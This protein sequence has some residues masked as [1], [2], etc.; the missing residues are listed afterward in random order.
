MV[1]SPVEDVVVSVA[2]TADA[3]NEAAISTA[4]RTSAVAADSPTTIT[5]SLS[6]PFWTNGAG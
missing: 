5:V 2:D 1:T 3:C 6:T 4:P